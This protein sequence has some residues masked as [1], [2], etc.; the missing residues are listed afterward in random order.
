MH[1]L[2]SSSLTS[3]SGLL[4]GEPLQTIMIYNAL[5]KLWNQYPRLTFHWEVPEFRPRFHIGILLSEI[6]R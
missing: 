4:A 6:V 3:T 2:P 5:E 1:A